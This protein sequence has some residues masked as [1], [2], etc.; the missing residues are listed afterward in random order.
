MKRVKE[1]AKMKLG[2]G[3]KT[4]STEIVVKR[5]QVTNSEC[6]YKTRIHVCDQETRIALR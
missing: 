3:A 2:R 6:K 1:M 4:A 5:S